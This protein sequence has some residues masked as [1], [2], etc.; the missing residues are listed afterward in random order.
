MDI[1]DAYV[2]LGRNEVLAL[3][4]EDLLRS[5]DG[6]GISK[7]MVFAGAINDAPNQ[8][9]LDEIE[10]HR[11]RLA[12]IASISP[13]RGD[14]PPVHQIEDWIAS[15]LVAGLKLYPGYGGEHYYPTDERLHPYFAA[16]QQLGRP[17]VV[18]MGDLFDKIPDSRIRYAMPLSIDDVATD[19]PDLRIIIAHMAWPYVREAAHMCFR[20]AQVYADVSGLVYGE[21]SPVDVRR[22]KHDL[23][24]FLRIAPLEKLLFA[25]DKP[26]C[27][28]RSYVETMMGV[29]EKFGLG[30]TF[31]YETALRLFGISR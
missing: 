21:F 29:A 22:V 14:Q 27:D 18:H 24:E 1:V 30:A 15:G 10:P 25:T 8:W 9:V 3:S 20:H 2:H 7:A 6:A 28:Q 13:L 19:F 16:L 26:I 4:V 31:F 5:M 11:D 23:E 17:V 12:A